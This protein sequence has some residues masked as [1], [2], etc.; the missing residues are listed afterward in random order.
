MFNLFLVLACFHTLDYAFNWHSTGEG[1]GSF[2]SG[3]VL[4]HYL[5]DAIH[6]LI[7]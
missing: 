2:V 7:A 6:L 3:I 5:Y 1:Q 4:P